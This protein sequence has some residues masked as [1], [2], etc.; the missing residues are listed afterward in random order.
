MNQIAF[1]ALSDA[2]QERLKAA[3]QD[4]LPPLCSQPWLRLATELGLTEAQ[5]MHQ[6]QHWMGR[7]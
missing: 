6:V 1:T 2:Q 5:V 3:I 4:G 7:A